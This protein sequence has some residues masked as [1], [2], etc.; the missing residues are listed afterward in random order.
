MNTKPIVHEDIAAVAKTLRKNILD[1]RRKIAAEKTKIGERVEAVKRVSST[2]MTASNEQ[3]ILLG[4]ALRNLQKTADLGMA[5]A[6]SPL[7]GLDHELVE[8]IECMVQGSPF[9]PRYP[10]SGEAC[11]CSECTRRRQ[12]KTDAEQGAARS[13]QT[14][15]ADW[16]TA[17]EGDDDTEYDA[18]ADAD[19]FRK[20]Q[21][22]LIRRHKE[23]MERQRLRDPFSAESLAKLNQSQAPNET[24]VRRMYLQLTKLVHPDLAYNSEDK[25]RRNAMM[26]DL[27]LAYKSGDFATML[28][29]QDELAMNSA[30]APLSGKKQND[31]TESAANTSP[32]EVERLRAHKE[33]L[34]DQ[35][36]SLKKHS[37]RMSRSKRWKITREMEGP[38]R[39]EFDEMVEQCAAICQ[40]IKN[41]EESIAAVASGRLKVSEFK[42][43][44]KKLKADYLSMNE[45]VEALVDSGY[46]R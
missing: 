7:R 22:E 29:I 19:F 13:K 20:E 30:P 9:Q 14:G 25:D 28:Q 3:S 10:E 36:K 41:L 21:E 35:L 32:E 42:K 12:E 31:E 37:Q 46:F 43:Q 16:E 40:D 44:L 15:A 23:N 38:G 18:D 17:G 45:I 27:A 4:Q 6:D 33:R 2:V 8:V 26:Q 1:L 5:P 34:E 39:T 11:T 24:D